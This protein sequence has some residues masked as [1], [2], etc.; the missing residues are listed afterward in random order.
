MNFGNKIAVGYSLFVVMILSMVVYCF[1]QDFYLESEN[2][3]EKELNYGQEQNAISN[4]KTL[5][6]ELKI[7][8]NSSLDFNF[9]DSVSN[10]PLDI[11]IVL[12]RPNNANLDLEL[13]FKGVQNKVSIPYDNLVAGIYNMEF[14]F[15]HNETE[16]LRKKGIYVSPK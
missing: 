12:K 5:G 7:E 15:T 9:P 14:S 10:L 2:Y 1:K 8:S 13:D 3:Y 4:F 6:G 11:K 16:F